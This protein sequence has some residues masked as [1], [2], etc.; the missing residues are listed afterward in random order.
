MPETKKP[1]TGPG[2]GLGGAVQ[3]HTSTIHPSPD[4]FNPESASFS[5]I[6]TRWQTIRAQESNQ[7]LDKLTAGQVLT[8][9]IADV[10]PWQ[11]PDVLDA[12]NGRAA[13]RIRSR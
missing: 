6:R 4:Q 10:P 9:L 8:G 13:K 12:L 7:R 5:Q 3:F 1:R 11:L 2:A